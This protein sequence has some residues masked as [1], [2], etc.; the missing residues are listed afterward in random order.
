[1]EFKGEIIMKPKLTT[2]LYYQYVGN[3]PWLKNEI[4]NKKYD[5]LKYLLAVEEKNK[6]NFLIN[7]YKDSEDEN[8]RYVSFFITEKFLNLFPVKKSLGEFIIFNK[9]NFIKLFNFLKE[10]TVENPPTRRRS[11][12]T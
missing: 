7:I 2:K 10:T 5:A 11:V 6:S 8:I 1:M 9:E 12:R 4:F 3:I